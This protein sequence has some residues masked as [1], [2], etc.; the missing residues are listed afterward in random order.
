MIRHTS[1]ARRPTDPSGLLLKKASAEAR[2]MLV[3][4]TAGWLG[5]Q[6]SPWILPAF[7]VFPG[8]GI[9][10]SFLTESAMSQAIILFPDLRVK[11]GIPHSK[12]QLWRLERDGKFPKRVSIT[13]GRYGW[14]E[15]EIDAFIAGR[16]AARDG[17]A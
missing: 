2:R 8:S 10:H 16:I 13:A 4:R 12:T 3:T 14:V 7:F 9:R 15:S 5:V 17:K 1:R 11:K 6:V